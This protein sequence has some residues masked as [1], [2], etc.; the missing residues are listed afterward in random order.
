MVRS[1]KSRGAIPKALVLSIAAHAT[2]LGLATLPAAAERQEAFVAPLAS[3]LDVWAGTTADLPSLHEIEVEPGGEPAPEGHGSSAIQPPPEPAAEPKPVAPRPVV[4]K[5]PPKR[6]PEP[7]DEDPYEG[8]DG[9]EPPR[10]AP[11]PAASVAPSARSGDGDAVGA[12]KRGG[13]FGAEGEVS[14]ARDLGRAFTRAIPPACQADAAWAALPTGAAGAVDVEIAIDAA[15]RI[16]GSRTLG[17]DPPPL[18]LAGLVRRTVALLGAGTFAV[19]SGSVSAGTQTIR[20]RAVVSD[21]PDDEEGGEAGL[22][23][24]YQG[25]RGLAGFTQPGGRHVEVRTEVLRVTVRANAFE[26]AP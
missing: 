14:S 19:Q 9:D 25:K 20:V 5:A 8:D 18:H 10:E 17:D 26:D 3:P 15:G 11:K 23:Y 4:A 21:V 6:A 7:V 13:D 2:L 16:V 1:A 24:E 22:A 12:P